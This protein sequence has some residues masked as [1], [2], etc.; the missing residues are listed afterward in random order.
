MV[1]RRYGFIGDYPSLIR[2]K[3]RGERSK[4]SWIDRVREICLEKV[5]G[6]VTGYGCVE[7]SYL[8]I[9]LEEDFD[10][11]EFKGSWTCCLLGCGGWSCSY[12]C[13]STSGRYV[14]FKVPLKYRNIFENLRLTTKHEVFRRESFEKELSRVLSEVS[15][16]KSL[17]HPNLVRF[18]GAYLSLPPILIYE[19]ANQGSLK[20]QLDNGFKPSMRDILLIGIQIGEALRHMHG[21]GLVHG[22][23]SLNNIF[24][25]DSI[26]K[27]GDYS[28]I[29]H[30]LTDLYK[31]NE[32]ECTPGFCSPEQKFEEYRDRA[33]EKDV[34]N[35]IDIYQLGNVLLYL[36]VGDMIDGIECKDIDNFMEKLWRRLSRI[37]N[38]SLRSLISKML[39]CEASERPSSE[40]VVETLLK[41]IDRDM[42]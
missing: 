11:K 15:K 12:L 29:I 10:L 14:V 5:A 36:L 35:R 3:R 6:L 42:S 23:I 33:V 17:D 31:L 28:S 30:L 21:R 41:I 19:Y 26:A 7:D 13:R 8:S 40:D 18:L 25:K 9:T 34:V 27:I 37:S 38:D 16:V 2:F 4:V 24:F 22:D 20:W 39:S 1:R 32:P